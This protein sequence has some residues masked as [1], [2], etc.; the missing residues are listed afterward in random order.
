MKGHLALRM[1]NAEFTAFHAALPQ[2]LGRHKAAAEQRTD[3]EEQDY[4]VQKSLF[5]YDP[6][7]NEVEVTTWESTT[8]AGD[9]FLRRALLVDVRQADEFAACALPGSVLLPL[10]ELPAKVDEL[11]DMVDGYVFKNVSFE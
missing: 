4:G 1:S 10:P 8:S 6:D 2:L 7:G 11:L 3:I 5:F 9:G